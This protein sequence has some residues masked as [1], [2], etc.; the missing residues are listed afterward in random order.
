MDHIYELLEL[1]KREGLEEKVY[2]Q[3]L[4]QDVAGVATKENRSSVSYL[5]NDFGVKKFFLDLT[6]R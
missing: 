3:V 5:F 4:E 2:I 1:V 6:G